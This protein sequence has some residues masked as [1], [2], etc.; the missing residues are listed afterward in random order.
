MKPLPIDQ[1]KVIGLQD[2]EIREKIAGGRCQYG[3]KG[4]A[5]RCVIG[6]CEGFPESYLDVASAVH[7]L[8]QEVRAT[9]QEKTG[10]TDRQLRTLQRCHDTI[11]GGPVD[12][13]RATAEGF[14]GLLRS[15]CDGAP[16]PE[17]ALTSRALVELVRQHC[18]LSPQD[19]PI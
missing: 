13:D 11:L 1:S 14:R 5:Y 15:W 9:L 3:Y 2:L 7:I 8:D 6:A 17:D 16:I 12:I 10:L 4:T 19:G 18:E